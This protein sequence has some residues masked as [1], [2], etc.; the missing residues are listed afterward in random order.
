MPHYSVSCSCSLG[1]FDLSNLYFW[2]VVKNIEWAL[3]NDI[4]FIYII[5]NDN[6]IFK[7]ARVFEKHYI[8]YIMGSYSRNI[9][10]IFYPRCKFIEIRLKIWYLFNTIA[11]LHILECMRKSWFASK[12]HCFPSLTR[13]QGKYTRRI[14]R[15]SNIRSSSYKINR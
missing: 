4:L 1:N 12:I 3:G 9:Y 11:F 13:F 2:W 7:L 14:C 8:H 5:V 10:I 15:T 6:P